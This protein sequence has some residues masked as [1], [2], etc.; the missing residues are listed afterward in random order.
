MVK[1]DELRTRA[2]GCTN[3]D[4]YRDATQ[5]VFG[6]G[7]PGAR[8]M[9][10]GEQ[11]GH[12]EDLEG[13]PFVGPA[14]RLLDGALRDAGIDRAEAYVT[15]VVKHFK[16]KRTG[17]RRIHQTPTTREVKACLP[18]FLGELEAIRPE[19]VTTLGGTAAKALLGPSFRVTHHRGEVLEY[20]GLPLVAT[21]HP[22]AVLRIPDRA[23]RAEALEGLVT[24]LR[25][26]A[27]V[28]A[29]A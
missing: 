10:V 16:F 13:E 12:D 9:L 14:G 3:C 17:K 24:D 26:A 25:L 22:S 6:V 7:R 11:P 1:L 15:N 23:A 28:A 8:L 20:A 29:D 4:L 2:A 27:K 21:I 19:V 18:W 5:T